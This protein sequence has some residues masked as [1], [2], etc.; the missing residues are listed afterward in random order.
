[1]RLIG[2]T[3]ALLLASAASAQE[4]TFTAG[5]TSGDGSVVPVLTWSTTPSA[6]GANP[7]TATGPANWAGAKQASGSVTLPAITSS[8]TYGLTCTWPAGDSITV[9]WTNP[10]QN[11]DG[12]PL[13]DLDSVV[14]KFRTGTGP[15]ATATACAAP[16]RCETARPPVS[17]KTYTGF[18]AGTWR[19]A[20]FAV[21]STG[22]TSDPS[23]EATKVLSSS[24]VTRSVAITVNPK[25]NPPTGVALD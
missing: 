17:P 20:A 13:T 1:M 24:N 8:M 23:A 14:F 12:T 9:S 2:L 25:P 6:P 16:V 3:A 7:C 19:V 22:V 4:L 11:T 21:N 10:T 18:A 5:T 15:L